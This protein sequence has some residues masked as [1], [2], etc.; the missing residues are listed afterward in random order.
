MY[1]HICIHY[2]SSSGSSNNNT[3]DNYENK[4]NALIPNSYPACTSPRRPKRRAPR[5]RAADIYIYI[6]T[7]IIYIYI[8]IY[9]L[10]IM[11]RGISEEGTELPALELPLY[12]QSAY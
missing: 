10:S 8:Y 4:S 7:C 5:A 11:D 6:Y 3:S 1:I 9:I 2:D 12:G